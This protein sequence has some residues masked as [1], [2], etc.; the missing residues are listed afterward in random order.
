MKWL[1]E[2]SEWIQVKGEELLHAFMMPPLQVIAA[3]I[4]FTILLINGHHLFE[5]P[6][7][8]FS[9]ILETK[10]LVKGQFRSSDKTT[11]RDVNR[12]K[13]AV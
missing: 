10:D 4:N 11:V 13:E 8:S 2:N 6:F 9:N 12:L 3:A 5:L 1:K 7:K